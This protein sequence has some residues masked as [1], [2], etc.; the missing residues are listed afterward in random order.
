MKQISVIILNRLEQWR[1][2]FIQ[3]FVLKIKF[4]LIKMLV[5]NVTA[6]IFGYYDV[7]GHLLSN[8]A[9]NVDASRQV[10]PPSAFKRTRCKLA[11]SGRYIT[12]LHIVNERRDEIIKE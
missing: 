7:L 2:K 3:I 12:C 10:A 6:R 5:D 1:E 9:V 11:R 8:S 4:K